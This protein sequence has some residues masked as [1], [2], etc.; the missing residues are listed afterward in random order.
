MTSLLYTRAAKE[1]RGKGICTLNNI[2]P[3]QTSVK[4]KIGVYSVSDLWSVIKHLNAGSVPLTGA[5]VSGTGAPAIS[6]F[7]YSFARCAKPVVSSRLDT[8]RWPY[9]KNV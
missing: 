7:R 5:G 8:V 4:L 3:L 9:E 2:S 6:L 1:P